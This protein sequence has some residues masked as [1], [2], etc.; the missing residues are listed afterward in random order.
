MICF[1]VA[2]EREASFVIDEI[3][4]VKKLFL[5]GKPVYE[6]KLFG[7]NVAVVIS[8]IGKVSAALSCQFAIDKYKPEAIINFGTA[9]GVDGT[10]APREYYAVK[11]CCQFDFDLRDVDDVPLGY[12]QEYDRVFFEGNTFRAK[13]LFEERNLASADRF[14]ECKEDNDSVVK[15]GC[16]LRD[17]EGGAIAQ[18]CASCGVPL[19]IIKGV[20]DVTGSGS[21]AEQFRENLTAVSKGFPSVIKKVLK[22]E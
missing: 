15:L 8:G 2:L 20:S 14:T 10:V 12:I 11:N 7:E 19:L 3:T 18:V 21:T 4:E 16:S 13:T 5:N 17:M 22:G 1:I 9:G 6:G